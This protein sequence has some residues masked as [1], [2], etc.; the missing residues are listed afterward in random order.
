LV[1]YWATPVFLD[2]LWAFLPVIFLTVVLVIRTRLE[3]H[4]LQEELPGY[5]EYASRVRYRLLP[6]V[7]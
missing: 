4:T 5:R 1:T 3:D 2:S 7:W 6:G